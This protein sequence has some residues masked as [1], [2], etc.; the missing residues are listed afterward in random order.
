MFSTLSDNV[1][2]W[3]GATKGD[4]SE[5]ELIADSDVNK[6]TPE[7]KKPTETKEEQTEEKADHDLTEDLD[8]L[9][10]KA[11]STAKEWGSKCPILLEAE[12]SLFWE[13]VLFLFHVK[14]VSLTK[15]CPYPSCVRQDAKITGAARMS[16]HGQIEGVMVK[17]ELKTAVSVHLLVPPF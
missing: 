16:R 15:L 7:E 14:S 5:K 2:S 12:F 4:S 1:N 9:G 3:F 10:T 13:M 8:E 17:V 11:I 6:E